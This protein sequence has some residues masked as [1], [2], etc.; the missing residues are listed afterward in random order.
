MC[1]LP[2][3]ETT[4]TAEYK[5]LQQ[6]YKMEMGEEVKMAYR[7]TDRVLNPT[8]IERVNVQLAVAA[9]HESTVAALRFYSQKEKYRDFG[10]TADFLEMLRKWFSVVNVKTAFTHVRLNDPL[11][12]PPR[13]EESLGL[14][15][16]TA[17]GTMLQ[18]W[19]DRKGGA[20][21]STD[22]SQAAIYTCR[23]LVGVSHYMLEEHSD[24]VH[25]VLL[26]KFQSDKIDE[27]RFGYLRKL[28]GG[29]FWASVRQ[30]FEGE[31]V[32]RVKGLVWLSGYSLGTVASVMEEA[33]QQ[34]HRDD[35]EVVELET[36]VEHASCAEQEPLSEGAEQAIAHVAGYLARSVMRTK[37]CY[38]C[39]AILVNKEPGEPERDFPG[40]RRRTPDS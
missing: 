39:H 33:R 27:G 30:F 20:K 13:K 11:R 8:S 19:Q 16:L 40:Y 4:V 1:N 32:I 35:A 31:A 36:L 7:M 17:F 29:N 2:Q 21:M 37:H 14:D 3:S 10:Q 23:G 26:G 24:L 5:H 34:R 38:A 25:Y 15:Y 6:L 18:V 9:T 28:A 22:T 12:A